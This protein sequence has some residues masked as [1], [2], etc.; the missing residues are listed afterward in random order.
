MLKFYFFFYL[1]FVNLIF[2]LGCIQPDD[3]QLENGRNM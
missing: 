1:F 3:G 2:L